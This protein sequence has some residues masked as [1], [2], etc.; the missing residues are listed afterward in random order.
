MIYFWRKFGILNHKKQGNYLR[1][2]ILLWR[3]R[4][5]EINVREGAS[6]H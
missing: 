2:S 3:A 4:Q 1:L 6:I 5:G